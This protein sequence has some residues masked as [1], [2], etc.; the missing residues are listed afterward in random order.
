MSVHPKFVWDFIWVL[1]ISFV[2]H[3]VLSGITDLLALVL[4]SSRLNFLS[5]FKF[6]RLDSW[7]NLKDHY[8]NFEETKRWIGA[9]KFGYLLQLTLSGLI[10][11]AI[12]NFS[13][14]PPNQLSKC[15]L[16]SPWVYTRFNSRWQ[17]TSSLL[18]QKLSQLVSEPC[19]SLFVPWIQVDR[20]V[21]WTEIESHECLR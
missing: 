15:R 2:I 7:S 13:F 17:H 5:I 14:G 16:Q 21:L 10:P 6:Y 9:A 19:D 8:L 20:W 3:H 11:L 4:G 1:S 18:S 12:Y